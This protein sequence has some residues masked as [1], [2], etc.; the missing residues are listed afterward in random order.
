[1]LSGTSRAGFLSRW[2]FLSSDA[3]F[4]LVLCALAV[5][6]WILSSYLPPTEDELY[7]WTWA[8]N[9]QWSYY[10]HPPMVAVLIKLSTAIFGD[11]LFGIRFFAPLV[12]LLLLTLIASLAPGKKILFLVLATPLTLF[13]AVL[14]TPDI[15]LLFFWACYLVW[16]VSVS[17]SFSPWGEDPISRVYRSSPIHWETWVLGGMILG[18][19]LLSKYSMVLAIP[20]SVLVLWTKYRVKSWVKGYVTHLIFALAVAS[21]ILI[22]NFKHQFAPLL[23]QWNHSLSDGRGVFGEFLGGQIAI[24][25]ALPLLMLGWILIRRTEICS[26]PL[27]QVCF[28]CFV[29][30]FLFS[31]FQAA[32]THVEANWA[33]MSYIAFWPLAQFLLN[34]NSIA[35]VEYFFLILGFV[36]PILVSVLVA[37]HLVHPFQKLAPEKDRLA[38]YEALLQLS[39]IIKA[40]LEL[41]SRDEVLFLPTYQWTSYFRFLGVPSEQLYPPGRASQFTLDGKDPCQYENVLVLRDEI[42]SNPESLNCFTTKQLLKVYPFEIRGKQ[43]SQLYLFEF[44][45]SL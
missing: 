31:L 11:S 24:V 14:M 41:N 12:H 36:P 21:P 33:L 29:F 45:R 27:L 43:F 15:P 23:F 16:L 20:C 37:I 32:K 39:K 42:D 22:F 34:K 2:T 5:F 30:P 10:D 1:M 17:K 38:K 44:S 4:F 18:L 25:G 28:Y 40:D 13:G 8:K 9:L 26:N 7:Y 6:H 3:I 19:G 35:I